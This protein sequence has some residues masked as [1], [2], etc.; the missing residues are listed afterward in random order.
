VR[1]RIDFDNGYVAGDA[2]DPAEVT[3]LNDLRAAWTAGH[4][5][6]SVEVEGGRMRTVGEIRSIEIDGV[7]S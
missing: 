3:V 5:W 6:M 7:R 2:T 4:H 1:F